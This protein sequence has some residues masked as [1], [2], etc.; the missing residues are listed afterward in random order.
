MIAKCA[1]PACPVRFNY[2][3]G[4]K[5]FRFRREPDLKAVDAGQGAHGGSHNAQHFW[6]CARCCQIFTLVYVESGG[7]MM[8]LL[9][10][11]RSAA[12]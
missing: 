4:G 8:K 2:R 11:E 7:V 9:Q 12:A 1:N 6:L 3:L 5:F 10:E